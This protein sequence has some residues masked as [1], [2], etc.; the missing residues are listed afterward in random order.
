MSNFLKHRP[1]MCQKF[2]KLVGRLTAD[3]VIAIIA[4]LTFFWATLYV[5]GTMIKM[6]SNGNWHEVVMSAF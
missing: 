4:Q 3:K 6:T 5:W 2:S 1:I